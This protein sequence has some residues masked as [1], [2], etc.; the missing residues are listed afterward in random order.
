MAARLRLVV[1]A[2][3]LLLAGGALLIWRAQTRAEQAER[4]LGLASAR[5]LSETFAKARDLRVATLSGEVIARGTD[6]GF[7]R[8][9]PTSLTMRYSYSIDYFLDLRR[10]DGSA[11]RWDAAN[12]TMT[13]RLPDVAPA[14]PNVDASGATRIGTTGMF[15]SRD[16]AQRLNGQVAARAALRAAESAKKRENLDR[17]RASARAA[18]QDLVAMPLRAAGLGEVKVVV[19]YPWEAQGSGETVQWDESRTVGQVIHR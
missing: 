16:A 19:R 10:I 4:E 15:M 6:P 5:T 9:L 13:V 17:A 2:V 8:V 7:A 12:R 18:M 11:Y 14:R 3:V 1:I